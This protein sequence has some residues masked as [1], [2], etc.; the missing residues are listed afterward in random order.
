MMNSAATN[1][2]CQWLARCLNTGK[3][4]VWTGPSA[5]AMW[6]CDTCQPAPE[7]LARMADLRRDE[8]EKLAGTEL[9]QAAGDEL[10]RRE[11]KAAGMTFRRL[12][13]GPDKPRVCASPM[14]VVHVAHYRVS[15]RPAELRGYSVA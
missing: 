12:A 15:G 14:R 10:R 4:L 3:R 9:R 8:L 13:D 5:R 1:P 6:A 11:C 2:R 7:R